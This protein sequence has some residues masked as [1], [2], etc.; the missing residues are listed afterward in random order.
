MKNNRNI[1]LRL[2]N[3]SRVCW[4]LASE[5]S[6]SHPLLHCLQQISAK[7]WGSGTWR[8]A[9]YGANT[10]AEKMLELQEQEIEFAQRRAQLEGKR[11]YEVSRQSSVGEFTI[12]RSSTRAC[13]EGCWSFEEWN[14][15]QWRYFCDAVDHSMQNEESKMMKMKWTKVVKPGVEA[16]SC[17]CTKSREV[18]K[19][20]MDEGR[21][22]GRWSSFI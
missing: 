7:R 20:K 4:R 18:W 2:S 17:K 15:S 19:W 5:W 21:E 22:A 13:V 14:Q 10:T 11:E 16:A 9:T 6:A 1:I 8:S 3:I 12:R